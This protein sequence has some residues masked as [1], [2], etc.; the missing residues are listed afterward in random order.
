VVYITRIAYT[1]LLNGE[2]DSQGWR[3]C[4]CSQIT[5]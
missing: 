4:N 1:T 5:H 2:R 3:S